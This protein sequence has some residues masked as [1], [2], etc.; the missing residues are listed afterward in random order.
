MKVCYEVA[1]FGLD[2]GAVPLIWSLPVLSELFAACLIGLAACIVL[3]SFNL[4]YFCG[5]TGFM[6]ALLL[7][8]G[9][10]RNFFFCGGSVPD[11]LLDLGH[12]LPLLV[13]VGLC[14]FA[15][16]ARSQIARSAVLGIIL[17][18]TIGQ[19]ISVIAA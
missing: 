7:M 9:V 4:V 1:H 2:G 19:G 8:L 14:V 18:G 11:Y 15:V 12:N 13:L 6:A 10:A 16:L 17:L 5:G 3:R